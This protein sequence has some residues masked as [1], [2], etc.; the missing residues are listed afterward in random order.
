MVC[1][2]SR[3]TFVGSI[4]PFHTCPNEEEGKNSIYVQDEDAKVDNAKLSSAQFRTVWND[5]EPMSIAIHKLDR[6]RP[7]FTSVMGTDGAVVY[8]T[9]HQSRPVHRTLQ[10]FGVTAQRAGRITTADAQ[11][12]TVPAT[13]PLHKHEAWACTFFFF[14]RPSS[15]VWALSSVRSY[16]LPNQK[17]LARVPDCVQDQP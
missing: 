6:Y 13:F 14:S 1:A 4:S 17:A 9:H 7:Q 15:Q 11:S 2:V 8:C 5:F 16:L 12:C 3:Q 10:V